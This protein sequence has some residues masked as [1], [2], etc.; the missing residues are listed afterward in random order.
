MWAEYRARQNPH[1]IPPSP[2][3]ATSL[4][5][6]QNYTFVKG[7][8]RPWRVVCRNRYCAV[9]T[10]ATFW[11]SRWADGARV[12]RSAAMAG[13]SS[14]GGRAE[15]GIKGR[16]GWGWKYEERVRPP[17]TWYRGTSSSQVPPV[18]VPSTFGVSRSR[19]EARLPSNE[20]RVRPLWPRRARQWMDPEMST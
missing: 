16:C 17:R 8:G 2:E 18:R 11:N 15:G 7:G 13:S 12:P 1:G 20:V 10:L 6:S 9:C 14:R 19:M 3:T 5:R 4:A